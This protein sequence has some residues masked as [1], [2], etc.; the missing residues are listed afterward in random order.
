MI[1]A[2]GKGV[3]VSWSYQMPYCMDNSAEIVNTAPLGATRGLGVTETFETQR[4]RDTIWL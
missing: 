2:L 3:A 4:L 1:Q